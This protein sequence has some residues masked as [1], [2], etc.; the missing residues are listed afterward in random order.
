MNE[1]G[2]KNR[3]CNIIAFSGLLVILDIIIEPIINLWDKVSVASVFV[4]MYSSAFTTL[5][6]FILVV[7]AFKKATER[8]NIF[9]FLCLI[10][11]MGTAF[12][13][14]FS[15]ISKISGISE[16]LNPDLAKMLENFSWNNLV[17]GVLLAVCFIILLN[18]FRKQRRGENAYSKEFAVGE[19]ILLGLCT[20]LSLLTKDYT[21]LT[22]IRIIASV[23]FLL[24]NRAIE[25]CLVLS[26]KYV[27]KKEEILKQ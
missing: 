24:V 1:T 17:T 9:A 21:E 4:W 26:V 19:F 5:P 14:G 3:L 25:V 2:N 27:E 13:S 6:L 8:F 18:A 11:Y 20:V 22:V 23:L 12:F 16:Q 10:S 15:V 7:F